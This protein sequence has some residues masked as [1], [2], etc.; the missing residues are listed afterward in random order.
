MIKADSISDWGLRI[1][2]LKIKTDSIAEFTKKPFSFR[3]L[4]FAVLIEATVMANNF[5]FYFIPQSEM[6]PTRNW[7][8]VRDIFSRFKIESHK[9]RGY[10]RD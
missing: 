1:G 10:E 5:F 2:E 8:Q 4:P 7:V 6:E 9:V 3:I